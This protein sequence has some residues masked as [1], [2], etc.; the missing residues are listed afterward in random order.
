MSRPVK[1][2]RRGTVDAFDALPTEMLVE[3]AARLE[4][5]YP[6]LAVL[7]ATC[8]R[9]RAVIAP[10][11][12]RSYTGSWTELACGAAGSRSLITWLGRCVDADYGV[13]YLA[14]AGRLE[15][16]IW[17]HDQGWE[18]TG[19]ACSDAARHGQFACL[20]YLHEQ[21]TPWDI[22]TAVNAAKGGDLPCLQYVLEKGCNVGSM[23][24]SAA[25]EY[26]RLVCLRYL[27]EQHCVWTERTCAA[28]AAGG[29][30]PCLQ[31]AHENGCP[32]DEYTTMYAALHG[33]LACLQYA[34]AH[35]CPWDGG[36]F[37]HVN[38]VH[39][40]VREWADAHGC[41]VDNVIDS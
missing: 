33:Q 10:A 12:Y 4:G 16:L 37:T 11:P 20:R 17:A 7:A 5:G 22:W 38:V 32:W 13:Q 6:A 3:I 29:H 34:H 39:P 41:T 8:R 15:D 14:G 27:H 1:R 30:L 36:L 2:A 31:Y 26:G 23:V 24:T 9:W 21:K 18:C 25:A 19:V 28:A 35:G 40:E